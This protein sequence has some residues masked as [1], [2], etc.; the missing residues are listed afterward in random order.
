[1]KSINYMK[2][3]KDLSSRY[4]LGLFHKHGDTYSALENFLFDTL[5]IEDPY[6]D[7]EDTS[8]EQE[9]LDYTIDESYL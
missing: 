9:N 4:N 3:Y 8:S 2:D 1:M 5:L 7:E 6:Y